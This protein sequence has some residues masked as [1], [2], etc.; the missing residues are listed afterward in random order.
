MIGTCKFSYIWQPW[1][2]DTPLVGG[3]GQSITLT[4]SNAPMWHSV[5]EVHHGSR[6]TKLLRLQALHNHGRR[7]QEAQIKERQW[8]QKNHRFMEG[9]EALLSVKDVGCRT[10]KC[11]MPLQTN[12]A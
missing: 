10:Y 3:I 7:A 8:I 9:C 1:M 2:L 12:L 4:M 11:R 5:L 6:V